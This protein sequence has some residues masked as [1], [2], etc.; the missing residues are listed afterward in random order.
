MHIFTEIFCVG[1][2]ARGRKRVNPDPETNSLV[3]ANAQ[4]QL[5]AASDFGHHQCNPND[6]TFIERNEVSE[7]LYECKRTHALHLCGANCNTPMHTTMGVVCRTT[8]LIPQILKNGIKPGAII[9]RKDLL[10]AHVARYSQLEH[11]SHIQKR[12]KLNPR[13]H[14]EFDTAAAWKKVDEFKKMEDA[15]EWHIAYNKLVADTNELRIRMDPTDHH[16]CTPQTCTFE[17]GPSILGKVHICEKFGRLHVCGGLCRHVLHNPDGQMCAITGDILTTISHTLDFKEHE[18]FTHSKIYVKGEAQLAWESQ[19]RTLGIAV[20][21]RRRKTAPA[22][23]TT[24]YLKSQPW[25]QRYLTIARQVIFD[26]LYSDKRRDL[27][28][29]KFYIALSKAIEVRDRYKRSKIEQGLPVVSVLSKLFF[30]NELRARGAH[31]RIN[32]KVDMSRVQYYA[33]RCIEFWVRLGILTPK[34]SINQFADY[35]V[36]YLWTQREGKEYNQQILVDKDEYLHY[37]RLPAKTS[38]KVFG[39]NN[40]RFVSNRNLISQCFEQALSTKRFDEVRLSRSAQEIKEEAERLRSFLA[41]S[42]T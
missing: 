21:L 41:P 9:V 32:L 30:M 39:V 17:L 3:L 2:A 38:L 24:D 7:G 4:T 23:L 16:R 6:C 5:V 28:Q 42:G 15:T 34:Q 33:V 25:C 37:A 27:D 12:V 18:N 13:L 11:E 26:I 40:G 31:I 20:P 14:E 10:D 35:T 29:R 1:M 36:G 19:Q 8:G 22:V